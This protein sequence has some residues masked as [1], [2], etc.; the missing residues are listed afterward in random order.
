MGAASSVLIIGGGFVGTEVA[1]ACIE[2]GLRTEVL[3]LDSRLV[4]QLGDDLAGLV[5]KRALAAGL[6]LTRVDGPLEMPSGQGD[7]HVVRSSAGQREADIVLTAVGDQPDLE[8]LGS[9]TMH[10]GGGIVVDEH[11]VA[12]PHIFAVGDVARVTT[13]QGVAARAPRNAALDRPGGRR[14]RRPGDARLRRTAS[15]VLLDQS[16]R[17]RDQHRR[18][19]SGL[20]TAGGTRGR[21]RRGIG[22]VPRRRRDGS[23]VAAVNHRLPVRKL[24]ASTSSLA[25]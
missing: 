17:A 2:A 9:M 24:R 4:P 20:R 14:S 10:R 5:T 21:S 15:P 23:T 1:W 12:A 18:P 8:W 7:L 25:Q 16:V 19:D 3:T 13:S 6:R 22:G 11:C